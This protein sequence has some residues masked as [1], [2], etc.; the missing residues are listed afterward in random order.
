LR[1]LLKVL[2]LTTLTMLAAFPASAAMV[3]GTTLQSKA[4]TAPESSGI[5]IRLLDIPS[6][7]Q[8]DPRAR[9]YI[10]DNVRPGATIERRIQVQNNT[11]VA[12]SVRVYPGAAD[13]VDGSFIGREGAAK[14]DLTT[15][16][17][18]A[19]TQLEMAPRSTAEVL[20]TIVVPHDAAEQEQYAVL[21]AEVR[22]PKDPDTQ[23]V[24][25]SRVGVRIY[26]S[27]GPGNGP[28]TEFTIDSLTAART[29]GDRPTIIATV[30]NSGGRAVDITG[31][32][33]LSDGPGGVS[34]GPFALNQAI[35]IAP[36]KSGEVSYI[37]EPGLPNG[38]WTAHV[39]LKSGLFEQKETAEITFPTTGTSE[40]INTRDGRSIPLIVAIIL[41]FALVVG[42]TATA[43][44]RKRKLAVKSA[45]RGPRSHR[46]G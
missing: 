9:S 4:P 2:V 11:D 41:I 18:A 19:R 30:T 42:G 15:W 6:A 5:G 37:L 7:T 1:F 40:P 14:N 26:L 29:K 21:W 23:I 3:Y 25:A 16:T 32:V 35:T 12:Q 38:P 44:L 20:V 33:T 13:I 39:K 34:A 8:N 45:D 28:P 43:L 46:L 27:V 31:D 17:S 24:S 22:A 36:G 10:V